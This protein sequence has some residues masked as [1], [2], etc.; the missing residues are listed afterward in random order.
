L[1]Y[2]FGQVEDRSAGIPA[3]TSGDYQIFGTRFAVDF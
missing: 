1:N 2:I 3:L